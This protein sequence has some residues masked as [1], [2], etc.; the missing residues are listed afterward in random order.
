MQ[1]LQP[2]L[3]SLAAIAV[4]VLLAV[5]VYWPDR[6]QLD[7]A[8]WGWENDDSMQAV[9]LHDFVH[10]AFRSGNFALVDETTLVPSGF[11]MAGANGG[12]ILEFVVS[13][14]TAAVA[15][16][17]RWLNLAILAW[18]PLNLVAFLP[19]GRH[20]W[21]R[22]GPTLAAGAA[23]AIL[24]TT[25]GQMGALRLTQVVLI[26]V[27]IAVLGLLRV[28]EEGGRRPILIAAVGMA[29][30]GV[31]YWFYGFFLVLLSPLF[32]AHG[33][34]RRG[35][36]A[37]RPMALDLLRAAGLT[38]LLILPFF[39]PALLSISSGY[40]PEG[41]SHAVPHMFPDVIQLFGD[42]VRHMRGWFSFVLLPAIA[43]TLWRGER[44]VLWVACALV[45]VVFALGPAQQNAEG[46]TFKLPYY[47]FWLLVPGL[48][49][50]LHPERWIHVGGLFLVVLAGDGLAR[51][52]LRGHLVW[53]LPVGGLVQ[54]FA[55]NLPMGN[56]VWKPPTVY[57]ALNDQPGSGIVVLPLLQCSI[58]SSWKPAH[59]RPMLGGMTE[60]MIEFLPSEQ[61]AF[62]E[63]SHLLMTLHGVSQGERLEL[64]PWQVDL[65][66]LHSAGLD[67]LVLDRRCQQRSGSA[68]NARIEEAITR[69]FGAPLHRDDTGAI[70]ALPT[71]GQPGVP[72]P[73][74]RELL[75][76]DIP[77]RK[78][79]DL[80]SPG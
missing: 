65:D 33:L 61:R 36:A 29:L 54:L 75:F 15:P 40:A 31:G 3:A 44:R 8:V 47:P 19:L 32:I 7:V 59:G 80:R 74:G 4:G 14:L 24:P 18:I 41:P 73:H 6:A 69:A 17:P 25:L 48:S 64:Q 1:R 23:F 66:A 76:P 30:T 49:R 60:E 78:S 56:W 16:W 9:Y 62:L 34:R 70:W 12:N 22:W 50:M 72:P 52:W 35:L 71:E 21:G 63:G 46:W 11:D 27:P 13:F 39:A 45:C 20:L 58:A 57:T 42:D 10:E 67:T 26:G 37:W 53:L 79:K 55:L 51:S 38:L 43:I 2:L 77:D 28:C 5:I 68:K